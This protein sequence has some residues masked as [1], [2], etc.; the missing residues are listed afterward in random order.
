MIWG[1]AGSP[2]MIEIAMIAVT[3]NKQHPVNKVASRFL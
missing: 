2:N 1:R 3:R